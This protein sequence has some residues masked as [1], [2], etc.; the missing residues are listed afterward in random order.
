[1]LWMDGT[2]EMRSEK[3]L[4][5][6]VTSRPCWLA[7]SFWWGLGQQRGNGLRGVGEVRVRIPVS[8]VTGPSLA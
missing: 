4:L 1:M 5:D 6:P 2:H 7:E 8:G 3:A